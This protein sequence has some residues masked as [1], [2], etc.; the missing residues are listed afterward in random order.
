MVVHNGREYRVVR[1]KRYIYAHQLSGL[2]LLYDNQ[3]DPYQLNNSVDKPEYAGLQKQVNTVLEQ[4]P[5]ETNDD[6]R[7]AGEYMRHF[8]SIYHNKN[9]LRPQSYYA[10][11]G[12]TNNLKL[13]CI[14]E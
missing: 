14:Q 11:F 4:K 13:V 5:K 1:T 2:W 7:P 8:Q 12:P 3:T 6:F 9:S 10:K